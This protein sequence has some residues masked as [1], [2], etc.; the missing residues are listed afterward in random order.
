[1]INHKQQM[2]V[3]GLGKQH[4]GTEVDTIRGVFNFNHNDHM[5]DSFEKHM[6]WE[7]ILIKHQ[8]W[9]NTP[10]CYIPEGFCYIL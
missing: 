4:W 2:G 1:M 7:L 6:K 10:F 8:T 9:Q 3:F 5:R